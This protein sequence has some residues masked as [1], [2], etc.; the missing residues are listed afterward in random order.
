MVINHDHSRRAAVLVDGETIV[1]I[2]ST[3]DA[4]AGAEVIDA[5]GC[6]VM[7]GGI[8]P[9]TPLEM[10]FMGTVTPDDFEGG[11]KAA[12]AGGPTMGVDFCL[13][14]PGPS[15]PAAHPDWSPKTSEAPMHIRHHTVV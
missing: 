7:P 2:G 9:H 13:P 10:P 5:G 11:T 6:Y 8:D 3:L 1:A 14:D 15:M 12:L 4:P